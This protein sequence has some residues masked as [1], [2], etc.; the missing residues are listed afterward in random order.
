MT[1]KTKSVGKGTFYLCVA[2]SASR[3]WYF[4]RCIKM[5][6]VHDLAESLVGDITPSCGIG[7]EEKQ[8]KEKVHCYISQ[9]T[10]TRYYF[11][12]YP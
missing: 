9:E 2:L 11:K 7:K 5:S 3:V 4:F 10:G 1:K 12:E 8:Q 6:L